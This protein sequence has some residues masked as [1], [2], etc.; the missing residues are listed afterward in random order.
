[1]CAEVLGHD[2]HVV[3]LRVQRRDVP[4]GALPAV[5][6]VVVVGADVRDVL[7]A[8]H[9]HEAAGEGR[10]ARRRV[11]DDAE[12]DRPCHGASLLARARGSGYVVFG[13]A[14]LRE[15][16][17]L[18]G[19]RPGVIVISSSRVSIAVCLRE[20]PVRLAQPRAVDRVADAAAV[21][22]ARARDAPL[23]V[24][25]ERLL[26]A[27]AEDVVLLRPASG[28][29][30]PSAR[31]RRSR[32][33]RC[34][35]RRASSGPGSSGRSRPSGPCSRRRSRRACRARPPSPG[36][37]SRSPPGRSRARSRAGRGSTPRR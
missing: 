14:V 17:A 37:G 20:E 30:S 29:R 33:S 28:A 22:E 7:L 9:A 26:G 4:L 35:A 12:D 34:G 21:G 10:L 15:H 32:G 13:L 2:V 31:R 11:A 5:V 16:A 23:E 24:L 3:A 6:A 1:M 25:A 27:L 18:A 8:E 36:A 19:C